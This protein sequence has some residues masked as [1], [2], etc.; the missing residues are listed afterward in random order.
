[1]PRGARA[2]SNFFKKM[3]MMKKRAMRWTLTAK[4]DKSKWTATT[5]TE[6]LQLALKA[7]NH[8]PTTCFSWTSHSLRKGAAS[9]ANAIKVPINDIHYAGGWSTNSTVL[10]S[11]YMD[12]AMAPSKAA[13][14]IFIQLKRDTPPRSTA[15][16]SAHNHEARAP[17]NPPSIHRHK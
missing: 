9:A 14:M 4:E 16:Y 1:M 7:T 13:Y 15:R 12:F 10:E 8:S 11:K 6:W 3:R 17:R 2:L 5:N